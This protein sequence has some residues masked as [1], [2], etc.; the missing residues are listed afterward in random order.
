MNIDVAFTP[1]EVQ[2][3]STKVCIV[4]DVIRATSSLTVIMSRKPRNVIITSTVQKAVKHSSQ[5]AVHPLLCGERGGLPPEGFDHGN[6]PREYAEA[7]L[8]GRNLVF[9]SSNGARA[10]ADVSIAPH[11]LLGSFLNA[12]F[13]VEEAIQL[14]WRDN[15][16]ILIVCAGRQEKFAI[17]DAYCAGYLIS[18]LTGRISADQAFTLGDGGQGALGIYGYFRDPKKLF[19]SCG[20]GEEVI[21]IGLEEDIA[22]LLEIDQFQTVPSLNHPHQTT[23]PWGFFL[24]P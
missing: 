8:A 7:D 4:V 16:D 19:S 22:F 3:L 6:S 11:V 13:V 20:S 17:D 10:V 1:L 24:L 12:S 14:A 15:L 23:T 2:A 9:T 18:L 5:Q 21:Q